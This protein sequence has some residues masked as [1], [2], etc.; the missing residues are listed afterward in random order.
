MRAK[1]KRNARR[2]P[3]IQRDE[4]KKMHASVLAICRAKGFGPG[5]EAYS[6]L[7]SLGA[8]LGRYPRV[9]RAKAEEMTYRW[10]ALLAATSGPARPEIVA[11]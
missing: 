1:C 2:N 4:I 11:W 5:S 8:A 9:R 6:L 7:C 3:Y 10:I